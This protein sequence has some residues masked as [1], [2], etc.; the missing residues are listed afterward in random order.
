MHVAARGDQVQDTVATGETNFYCYRFSAPGDFSATLVWTDPS[1]PSGVFINLVNDLHLAGFTK[2]NLSFANNVQYSTTGGSNPDKNN[3]VERLTVQLQA[4][5][6]VGL[7]V[8]GGGVLLPS[9]FGVATDAS[10]GPLQAYS[11]VVRGPAGAM[12][13]AR[14]CPQCIPGSQLACALPNGAGQRKCGPDGIYIACKPTRCNNGYTT[15]SFSTQCIAFISFTNILIYASIVFIVLSALAC[16]PIRF[17]YD[18][19]MAERG[20]EGRPPD[21]WDL[22]SIM[23]PELL[24]VVVGSVISLV[25]SRYSPFSAA[26]L[27]SLSFTC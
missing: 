8:Q 25:G 21:M 19:Y 16:I 10:R 12:T 15:S 27:L 9:P 23:R 24:Q 26:C 20:S 3:N 1:S 4:G 5:D 6:A 17:Y 18:C 14:D 22:F 11:L 13:L 2:G 7:Q